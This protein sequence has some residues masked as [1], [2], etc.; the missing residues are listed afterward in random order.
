MTTIARI[1]R[2]FRTGV[3]RVP[4]HKEESRASSLL[5][6]VVAFAVTLLM[7]VGGAPAFDDALYPNF[8]GQ[9]SRVIVPGLGGQPSFDQTKPWGRGQEAP[10]TPEYQATRCRP[11]WTHYRW[12]WRK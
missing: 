3:P 9:W 1:R 10:L 12:Q 6:G 8:K 2:Y 11:S 7:T 5:I 4:H